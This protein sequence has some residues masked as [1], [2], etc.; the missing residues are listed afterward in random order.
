[1]T[2]ENQ[3]PLT[4]LQIPDS[5]WEVILHQAEY[6]DEHAHPGKGDEFTEELL[7]A[8][9]KIKDTPETWRRMEPGSPE[10]RYGP[11]KTFDYVI[12]YEIYE[13]RSGG[14]VDIYHPRQ[15]ED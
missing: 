4:S 6:F 10:R 7:T 9:E 3:R 5:L 14:V 15:V 13:D 11:T 2:F 8:F 1:M 12:V